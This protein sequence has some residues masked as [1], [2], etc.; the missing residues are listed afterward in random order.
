MVQQMGYN[1]DVLRIAYGVSAF[2]DLLC[3]ILV[4]P[5]TVAA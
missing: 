4:H 3:L 1:R 5:L 2:V